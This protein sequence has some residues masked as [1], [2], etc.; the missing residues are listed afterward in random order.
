MPSLIIPPFF[1]ARPVNGGPL[2]QALPK[3]GNWTVEGKYNG[4]RSWVH[5]PTGTM[6]NRHL[7]PLSIADEFQPALAMLRRLP[8]EWSDTEALERR[9]GVGRGSLILFDYLPVNPL[10][11]YCERNRYINACAD[12][13]GIPVHKELDRPIANDCVYLPMTWLMEA[14]LG[15]WDILPQCNRTLGCEFW[16]GL[17]A[18]RN[19]SIYPR[20]RRSPNLDFPFWMKHRW[21]F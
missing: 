15:L 14:A 3:S 12:V 5:N 7:E 18:K 2:D 16:E 6:F 8:W 4:W 21:A 20:Q 10:E 19:D 13:V 17:V 1:P 11:T 9:H